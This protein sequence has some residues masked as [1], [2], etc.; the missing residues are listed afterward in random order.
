MHKKLDCQKYAVAAPGRHLYKHY[1]NKNCTRSH[2]HK[3]V[4]KEH[5]QLQMWNSFTFLTYFK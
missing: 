5:F 2:I 3:C 1:N 4:T